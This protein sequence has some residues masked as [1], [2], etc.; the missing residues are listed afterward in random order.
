MHP[1]PVFSHDD[2]NQNQTVFETQDHRQEIDNAA[3]FYDQDG[4][5]LEDADSQRAARMDLLNEELK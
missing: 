5:M 1:D 4:A 2:F 3:D